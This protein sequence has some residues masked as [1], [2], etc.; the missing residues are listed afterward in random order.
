LDI[1]TGPDVRLKYRYI[2]KAIT[3]TTNTAPNRIIATRVAE[4][5]L[6]STLLLPTTA[7]AEGLAE[8]L[9]AVVVTILLV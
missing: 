9:L 4:F 5:E 3:T 8:E 6:S 2:S 7:A 1:Q